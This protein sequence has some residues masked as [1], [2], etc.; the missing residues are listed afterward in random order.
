[1][2]HV[3]TMGFAFGFPYFECFVENFIT[4]FGAHNLSHSLEFSRQ[5]FG[6]PVRIYKWICWL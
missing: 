2:F 1:M 3:L 6:K 5:G 4:F